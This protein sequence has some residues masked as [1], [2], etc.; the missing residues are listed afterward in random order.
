MLTPITTPGQKRRFIVYDLEWFPHTYEVRLV[1]VYDGARFRAYPS[2]DAF[3]NGEMTGANEGAIFFAH[4]GGLA[5]VQFVLERM[6]NDPFSGWE[7]NACFSGSSAII[8]RA[9]KARKSWTFADS[10]WLLRDKLSKIAKSIGMEKGGGDY[11]CPTFPS[12]GH[13]EGKCIFWAPYGILK[14]YNELDCRILWHAIDQF[15][16]ELLALGGE[17]ALT[18]ASCAMRLF[19]GAYLKRSIPT[20]DA[21]NELARKAY[22]ASRVEVFRHHY[23]GDW[24]QTKDGVVVKRSAVYSDVNSSFPFSM[25]KPQPGRMTRMGKKWDDT[26][27]SLVRAKVRVP[28]MHVPP[29]PYRDGARVYFPTGSWAGWFSGVDLQLLLE[30]GGNIDSVHE[31]YDFEPF[32]DFGGYVQRL[33]EM[34]RSTKDDFR[35]MLLKLLLN[36]LY[37]KTA[38]QTE[39]DTL[40][41]GKAPRAG[42][43]QDVRQIAPGVWVGTRQARV[44]HA[45]V[46]IAMNVTAE[47]R[48]LLTRAIWKTGD[49]M[50]CDTDSITSEND[51]LGDSD[52]LGELKREYEVLEARFAAAKLYRLRTFD[53]KTGKIEDKIRAKG[54]TPRGKGMTADEFDGMV[55]GVP[56]KQVRMLRVREVLASG[57]LRPREQELQKRVL[58]AERPK[59]APLADGYTRPWNIEELKE[60]DKP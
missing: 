10:Y 9:Q 32:D 59:R 23:Q 42:T 45:W 55:R 6:L 20:T 19:R 58:L 26:K 40:V 60:E 35:K 53:R 31:V 50:Y 14:D 2:V 39:K 25:C 33:Y 12:C 37:G 7:I 47:S 17:M 1:G 36:S 11:Y 24:Q 5:D 16:N 28:D 30:A 41:A 48:A 21:L 49:A 51:V 34:R 22:V 15:Q 4:A 44:E 29:I 18:T 54:F 43:L 46:P 13:D 57:D 56:V 8:V 38:E 27:L 52:K 3:L